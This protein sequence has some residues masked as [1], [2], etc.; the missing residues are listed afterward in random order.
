[1]RIGEGGSNQ[2]IIRGKLNINFSPVKKIIYHRWTKVIPVHPYV[3]IVEVGTI[4]IHSGFSQISVK[5]SSDQITVRTNMCNRLEKAKGNQR[6]RILGDSE[7]QKLDLIT[8]GRGY[9]NDTISKFSLTLSKTLVE[10]RDKSEVGIKLWT[11]NLNTRKKMTEPGCVAATARTCGIL[12]E[13]GGIGAAATSAGAVADW[14]TTASGAVVDWLATSVGVGADSAT[15]FLGAG[16]TSV[17]RGSATVCVGGADWSGSSTADSGKF[18]GTSEHSF[19]NSIILHESF[20]VKSSIRDGLRAK[21]RAIFAQAAG[22]KS[23]IP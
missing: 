6:K 9:R 20:I 15:T 23:E 16:T 3:N 4:S 1:M 2:I 8:D 5:L 11:Q 12:A 14:A 10:S 18:Q 17:V 7:E 19:A 21:V 22:L 13:T